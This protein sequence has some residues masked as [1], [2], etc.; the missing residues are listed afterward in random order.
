MARAAAKNSVSAKV[1][2]A[3][4]FKGAPRIL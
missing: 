1:A 4:I 2:A 3:S